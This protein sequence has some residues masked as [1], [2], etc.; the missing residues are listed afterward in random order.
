MNVDFFARFINRRYITANI[1][2]RLLLV[3]L[4]LLP[5]LL[6]MKQKY[7]S[8]FFL[9]VCF[10]CARAFIYYLTERLSPVC[11]TSMAF[12]WTFRAI[13]KLTVPSSS[14]FDRYYHTQSPFSFIPSSSSSLSD[15][16]N[17]M[18][19]ICFLN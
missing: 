1:T 17:T 6:L 11:T 2:T 10:V 5:V 4:L 16:L 3:L 8:V 15:T 18:A 13:Y 9:S 14:S 12:P 19:E 7:F